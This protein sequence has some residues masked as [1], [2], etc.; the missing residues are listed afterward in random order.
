MLSLGHT[1][2]QESGQEL[3][4]GVESRLMVL[5]TKLLSMSSHSILGWLLSLFPQRVDQDQSRA[6]TKSLG[7]TP[8]AGHGRHALTSFVLW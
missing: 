2:Q 4:L 3:E 5:E 7:L 1:F 6:C 8:A